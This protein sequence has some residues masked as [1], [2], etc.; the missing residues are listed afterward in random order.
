MKLEVSPPATLQ[1]HFEK[2]APADAK[3]TLDCDRDGQ[4][5][6]CSLWLGDDAGFFYSIGLDEDATG[7]SIDPERTETL[8]DD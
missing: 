8:L 7:W 4:G 2:F 6:S 1:E 5:W 3:P